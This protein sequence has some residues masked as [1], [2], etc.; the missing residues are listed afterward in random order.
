MDNFHDALNRL[1]RDVTLIG[2]ESL[3]LADF[4]SDWPPD[5]DDRQGL[6]LLRRKCPSTLA[7]LDL[8][9]PNQVVPSSIPKTQCPTYTGF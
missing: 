8:T 9:R 2:G 3:Q 7:S 4:G 6:L 5:K 1:M